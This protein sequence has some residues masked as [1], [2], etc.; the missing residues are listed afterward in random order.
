MRRSTSQRM[1]P[2]TETAFA[3]AQSLDTQLPLSALNVLGISGDSLV[4][5]AWQLRNFGTVFSNS[6]TCVQPNGTSLTAK[7]VL[8]VPTAR[9]ATH[10]TPT[11]SADMTGTSYSPLNFQLADQPCYSSFDLYDYASLQVV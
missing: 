8:G 11:T 1:H 10:S 5:G 7:G 9:G 6:K 4:E 3:E 2:T